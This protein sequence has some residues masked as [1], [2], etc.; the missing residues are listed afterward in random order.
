MKLDD[1]DLVKRVDHTLLA[2]DW[3]PEGIERLCAEALR[4]G[5][6][7]VCVPPCAVA[8]CKELLGDAVPVC[9]VIGFPLGYSAT[10]VKVAEAAR[11]IADGADEI[12]MV[13]NLGHLKSGGAEAV[14]TDI[15]ALVDVCHS[16]GA[17]LKV[18][19]EACLLTDEEKILA[20]ELVTKAGADYIK[21]ST[22]F[23]KGGATAQD[24]ALLRAHVGPDVK[25]KAA[26]GIRT[27]EAALAMAR[28]GADRLGMSAAVKAFGLD[29]A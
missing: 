9:T 28:A 16:N 15:L 21:T 29:E 12:D 6:A 1:A 3:T 10:E 11:A 18:I 8:R 24:V 17:L 27:A 26:G 20:C 4:Y 7:S 23:A 19:I 22:G 25:V 5:F 14:L 13:I 2:Q